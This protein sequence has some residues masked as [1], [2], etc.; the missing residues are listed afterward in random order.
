M[1]HLAALVN[2]VW[3]GNRTWLGTQT[4]GIFTS[5]RRRQHSLPWVIVQNDQRKFGENFSI[6]CTNLWPI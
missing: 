6:D 5:V 3:H 2:K 1:I 4:Q